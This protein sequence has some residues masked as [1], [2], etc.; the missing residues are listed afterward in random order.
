MPRV[1]GKRTRKAYNLRPENVIGRGGEG[2]V[3][4]CDS[5]C[6]KVFDG[7]LSAKEARKIELLAKLFKNVPGLAAPTEL[8]VSPTTGEK[9]VG[10]VVRYITGRTLQEYLDARATADWPLAMKRD[11]ATDAARAAAAVHA[12]RAPLVVFGD[13]LTAANLMVTEDGRA[14]F[15]DVNSL[16]VFGYRT[17][18]GAL[19]DSVSPL[20]TPGY[21]PPEVLS[22]PGA[23]PSHAA[24][25]FALARVLFELLNGRAPTEPRPVPAAVGLDPDRA[26]EEGLFFPYVSHPEFEPPTYDPVSLPDRIQNLFRS[27]FLG[28]P[29]QRPTARQ[30]VR[31]LKAWARTDT[32][33]ARLLA[34]LAPNLPLPKA[35]WVEAALT[36]GIVLVAFVMLARWATSEVG[37][38][39]AEP[40]ARREP[41]P[42]KPLGPPAYR[43]IFK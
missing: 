23:L 11:V 32:P 21:V 19:T 22:H 4:R 37:R 17:D 38:V 26:V 35:R 30:W 18:D 6:V 40:P 33:L 3:Y 16:S 34:L 24:D 20:T 7:G 29:D 41:L 14:V 10:Y 1:I 8:V 31:A 13:G 27:A 36:A 9:P 5:V 2:T 39:L 28:R 42:A 25:R 15:V 12:V 43:E